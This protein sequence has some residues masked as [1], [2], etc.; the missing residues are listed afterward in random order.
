VV[1]WVEHLSE[2][3]P[4]YYNKRKGERDRG[5]EE[6]EGEKERKEGR[7]EGKQERRKER[8]IKEEDVQGVEELQ[9]YFF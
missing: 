4:P 1:K 9:F 7:K 8:K 5:K 6:R 3:T 2:F